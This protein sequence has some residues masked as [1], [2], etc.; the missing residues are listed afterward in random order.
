RRRGGGEGTETGVP[1]FSE[2]DFVRSGA[3][4]GGGEYECCGWRASG[5]LDGYSESAN[6]DGEIRDSRQ[7]RCQGGSERERVERDGRWCVRQCD[8]LARP[9]GIGAD[10]GRGFFEN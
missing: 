4:G 5:G 8:A 7:R 3:G 9:V 1:G 2:I 6:A 10:V